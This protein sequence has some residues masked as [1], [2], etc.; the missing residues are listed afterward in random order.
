MWLTI[1]NPSW[2]IRWC[3][4]ER[5]LVK[6]LG[7][8][9]RENS[10]R[11]RVT[12]RLVIMNAGRQKKWK[13]GAMWLLVNQFFHGSEWCYCFHL[14]SSQSYAIFAPTQ[15]SEAEPCLLSFQPLSSPECLSAAWTNGTSLARGSGLWGKQE[16]RI[17]QSNWRAINLLVTVYLT[18][19]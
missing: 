7:G 14:Q 1:K 17:G 18:F 12:Q 8:T 10:G 19:R 13:D 15:L 3:S 5:E 11:W 4:H 16:Y 6:N 2:P 9:I